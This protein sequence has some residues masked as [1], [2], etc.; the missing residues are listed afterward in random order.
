MTELKLYPY[1]EAAL[2]VCRE[3]FRKRVNNLI[4]CYPPGGGKTETASQAMVNAACGVA[5]NS[6]AAGYRCWFVV[7]RRTLVRQT[8]ARLTKYGIR[9][10]VI[11]SGEQQSPM[12]KIQV[13]SLDTVHSRFF[14]KD[15]KW[16]DNPPM[17]PDLL[18]YD[19]AHTRTSM[20]EEVR[21]Q[22]RYTWLI[23]LTA[24]PSAPVG[25]TMRDLGYE[26]IV[27]GPKTSW[28]IENNYLVGARYFAPEAY[29]YSG[30]R[31]NKAT[32]EFVESS[33]DGIVDKPELIGNLV[34]NYIELGEDRPFVVFANSVAH[35]RHITQRFCDAGIPCAHIDCKV[36]NDRREELFQEVRDGRIRGLSNYGILDRGFDLDILSVCILA[37]KFRNLAT[38]IQAG[39][40]VTRFA[41]GKDM[42]IIIDHAG[43]VA[44]H[45]F[46]DDDFEWSLDE[47]N[48]QK[49]RDEREKKQ[50][51][52]TCWKCKTI[53]TGSNCP[54]CSAGNNPPVICPDCNNE[55]HGPFCHHCGFKF[56]EKV[57]EVE[58]KEGSLVEITRAGKKIKPAE[59][60]NVYAQLLQL[61]LDNGWLRGSIDHTFREMFGHWPSKKNG[62]DPVEPTPEIREFAIQ[63]REKY[64]R[65]LN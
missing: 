59:K 6:A 28:L 21:K 41:P 51:P 64:A 7:H 58:E 24:T 40:R 2:E 4:L 15:A 18:I 12:E 1:Q 26:Q 36:D 29:D 35:S 46:L 9:H 50:K 55:I 14:K 11:M 54:K 37:R 65:S 56:P 3:Q 10:G 61:S 39:C 33:A 27:Y 16:K 47:D 32:G 63:S 5:E 42:A 48:N 53:Y 52:I 25:K 17:N 20:F 19:E 62:I 30:V 49:S 44:D 13:V 57:Q 43:N 31:I 60:A 22:L 38:Y 23:G 45:G 8:S 34:Q